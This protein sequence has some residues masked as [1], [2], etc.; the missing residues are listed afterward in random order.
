VI[1]SIKPMQS[2]LASAAKFGSVGKLGATNGVEASSS[3]VADR[4]PGSGKN[5]DGQER[6]NGEERRDDQ[7]EV[8]LGS[9][10][11]GDERTGDQPSLEDMMDVVD[12]SSGARAVVAKQLIGDG[13]SI[14]AI[15]GLLDELGVSDM[16]APKADTDRDPIEA[17]DA[18]EISAVSAH[19]RAASAYASRQQA[20]G[21]TREG[22][23]PGVIYSK[24]M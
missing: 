12:I 11:V 9:E 16:T 17:T 1:D 5:Y 22:L 20:S 4:R 13:Y 3:R 2:P 10:W 14:S 21:G 19:G 15:C 6:R 8:I 18:M 7:D 24:Q 23:M